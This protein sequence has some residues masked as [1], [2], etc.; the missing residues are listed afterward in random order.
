ML[1]KPKVY[2]KREFKREV[3]EDLRE[4]SGSLVGN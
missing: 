2:L 1:R 4:G 3:R